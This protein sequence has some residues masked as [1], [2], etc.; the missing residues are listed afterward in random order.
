MLAR[1]FE[2][3]IGTRKL[4]MDGSGEVVEVEGS[5]CCY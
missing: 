3:F 5:E 4:E 1:I 2:K